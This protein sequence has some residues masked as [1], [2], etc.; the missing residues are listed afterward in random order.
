MSAE[1]ADRADHW[2]SN[3]RPKATIPKGTMES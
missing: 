3:P 1:G 2:Y